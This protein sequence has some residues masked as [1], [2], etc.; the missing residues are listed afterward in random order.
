[1]HFA[2]PGDL[3]TRTGGYGYDRRVLAALGDAGWDVHLVPLWN[4]FPERPDHAAAEAALAAVPDDCVLVIDGLAFGVLD[5]WAQRQG[6][7]VRLFALV[8][9]PLA[10]E[11]GLSEDV[12]ATYTATER[13][14]LSHAIGVVVTSPAT[15]KTLIESYGV[16]AD[17]LVVATPGTDPVPLAPGSGEVPCI[18]SVGSLTRRKGHDVLIAALASLQDLSWNC[19]IV[20]SQHLDPAVA[21]QLEKQIA[22]CHLA[23]RVVLVGE[24]D[25]ARSEFARADIFALASRYEGYGMVFA[26]ALAHGLPIVGCAAGAVPDVVPQAAGLL[27]PPDDPQAF[28]EALGR[29]LNDPTTRIEMA[30]AAAVAGAQLPSWRDAAA[31]IARFIEE[32]G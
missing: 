3:Q 1:L 30:D 5:D 22:D 27:V 19:R 17:A 2:Y 28:A 7:R 11:T 8:H 15:A 14:A 31:T 18:L 4:G 20:G 12:Q 13:R 10:L 6:D 26:E 29:L 21:L 25:D 24:V 23:D 16:R 9:H 32:R